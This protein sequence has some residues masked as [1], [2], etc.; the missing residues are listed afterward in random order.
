MSG[1]SKCSL[2]YWERKGGQIIKDSGGHE[3][4]WVERLLGREEKR[5]I[6]VLMLLLEMDLSE[7][8]LDRLLVRVRA[9]YPEIRVV[10]PGWDE[11]E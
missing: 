3:W 9:M 6:S 8:E 11:R 2:F 7:K 5:L 1:M 4:D 10:P